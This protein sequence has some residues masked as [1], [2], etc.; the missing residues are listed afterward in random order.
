MKASRTAIS[1]TS[2]GRRSDQASVPNAEDS[3]VHFC[4]TA[5]ALAQRIF[6][7][8]RAL[9]GDTRQWNDLT[10]AQRASRVDE[11]SWILRL[12]VLKERQP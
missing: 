11:A 8:Y 7:A 12:Q 9:T 4:A 5:C 2:F 1:P 6:E 10:V 3:G